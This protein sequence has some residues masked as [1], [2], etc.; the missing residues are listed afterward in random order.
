MRLFSFIAAILFCLNIEARNEHPDSVFQY[1]GPNFKE[2]LSFYQN[3]IKYQIKY[4]DGSK[5]LKCKGYKFDFAYSDSD[6][7]LVFEYGP[8]K[9]VESKVVYSSSMFYKELPTNS[10]YVYVHPSIPFTLTGI[11]DNDTIIYKDQVGIVEIAKEIDRLYVTFPSCNNKKHLIISKIIN[12]NKEHN[13]VTLVLNDKKIMRTHR[14]LKTDRGIM[15]LCNSN[16]PAN[17]ILEKTG[18]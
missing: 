5:L 11:A 9:N 4:K 1:N 2:T 6:T 3:D 10:R 14:F 18:K 7:L 15:P 13:V 16:S 12:V 17:Y 8:H